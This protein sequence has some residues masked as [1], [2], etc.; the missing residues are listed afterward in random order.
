MHIR[1]IYRPAY[2]LGL[3]VR[4]IWTGSVC[5]SILLGVAVTFVLGNVEFT[6]GADVLF[7]LL[8]ALF[9]ARM[10]C[11]ASIAS[12]I[13]FWRK[14]YSIFILQCVHEFFQ[15]FCCAMNVTICWHSKFCWEE[16]VCIWISLSS[17]LW[18]IKFQVLVFIHSWSN[19]VFYLPMIWKRSS[20]FWAFVC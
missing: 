16:C 8:S 10:F 17:C 7:L 4:I 13:F 14:W 15:C 20:L 18:N 5:G 11:R 1:F 6:L 3:Y 9:G 12:L 2:M 19:Y